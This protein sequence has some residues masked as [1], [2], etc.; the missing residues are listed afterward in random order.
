MLNCLENT[1]KRQF[2]SCQILDL[3]NFQNNLTG[4]N[5]N[6]AGNNL[7]S[8]LKYSKIIHRYAKNSP[9]TWFLYW[10]L[11]FDTDFTYFVSQF[12]QSCGI[13]AR[14][15]FHGL[16]APQQSM[17]GALIVIAMAMTID[18]TF[19]GLATKLWLNFQGLFISLRIVDFTF[20][21]QNWLNGITLQW[22]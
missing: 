3:I 4:P 14:E 1:L 12:H 21:L 13:N 7:D 6:T 9:F 8:R 22:Q 18:L 19:S 5:S 11:P 15:C 2:D 16:A 17:L 20:L 10:W